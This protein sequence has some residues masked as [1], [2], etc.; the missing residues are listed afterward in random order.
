MRKKLVSLFWG[1]VLPETKKAFRGYQEGRASEEFAKLRAK[2]NTP[3]T[4]AKTTLVEIVM[5][6][7]GKTEPTVYMVSEAEYQE[8]KEF[9]CGC[10]VQ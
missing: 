8:L 3:R 5:E 4:P 9:L 1:Y 2:R 6:V 10:A 7:P